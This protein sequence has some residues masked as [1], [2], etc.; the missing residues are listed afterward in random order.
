MRSNMLA[1]FMPSSRGEGL[2]PAPIA[3]DWQ[4]RRMVPSLK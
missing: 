1:H 4:W 3:G 2:S